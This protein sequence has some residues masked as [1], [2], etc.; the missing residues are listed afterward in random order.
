[1]MYKV[2]NKTKCPNAMWKIFMLTHRGSSEMPH[3]NYVFR[4]L[5]ECKIFLR[6][7]CD[8]LNLY[9]GK[10]KIEVYFSCT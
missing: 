10:E 6:F 2:R 9:F 1:M 3:R 5:G 8:Y 7:I 4:E